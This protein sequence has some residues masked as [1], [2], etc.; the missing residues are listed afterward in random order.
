MKYIIFSI[1]QLIFQ[2][3]AIN[4]PVQIGDSLVILQLQ[5]QGLGKAFVHLHQNETTSLKAARLIIKNNG[6]CLLTVIHSGQRNIVFNLN[7]KRYEFDPN[8]IFSDVGI[9]KTL[10]QYSEVTPE[11]LVEVNNFATKIKQLLPTGK[12]IA[13]HNNC[14]YSLINYLPG[15]DMVND[16]QAIHFHDKDHYRNFFMVTQYYDYNRIEALHYN[17]VMQSKNPSDDGSLSVYF[18]NRDY[19]NVEAGYDQLDAQIQMLHDA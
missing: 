9:K 15:H 14:T 12:I 2:A 8:R 3:D 4:T 16:A 18:A 11:A 1:I 13:V 5:Q 19:I 6:G 17:V 10:S 7:H